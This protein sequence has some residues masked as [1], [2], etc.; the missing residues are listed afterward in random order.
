MLS[1]PLELDS[2]CKLVHIEMPSFVVNEQTLHT[3]ESF[4]YSTIPQSQ[5]NHIQTTTT[6][7][8][9]CQEIDEL[10]QRLFTFDLQ[11][12]LIKEPSS[13]RHM[14]LSLLS[15]TPEM[16]NLQTTTR[17]V[18]RR[19]LIGIDLQSPI[20]NFGSM[21][22]ED[23]STTC[24]NLVKQG[25]DTNVLLDGLSRLI[26]NVNLTWFYE[27][28][29]KLPLYVYEQLLPQDDKI[30]P[31]L[32]KYYPEETQTSITYI[33]SSV[34]NV[35][36]QFQM[37]NIVYVTDN[38]TI[39]LL[40]Q[41][42][43][44]DLEYYK[45]FITAY[46]QLLVTKMYHVDYPLAHVALKLMLSGL[47]LKSTMLD[48]VKHKLVWLDVLIDGLMG[49]KPIECLTSGFNFKLL[50]IHN[51]ETWQKLLN[52]DCTNALLDVFDNHVFAVLAPTFKLFLKPLTVLKDA[53]QIN[54]RVK[55]LRLLCFINQF[56]NP[57]L[58]SK[59]LSL[60]ASFSRDKS[61]I[62]RD[63]SL[64]SC[65]VSNMPS[66][67]L[68]SL[69]LPCLS[70]TSI[71]V[72]KT[73]IKFISSH[74]SPTHCAL[75][76]IQLLDKD[77][78]SV[79]IKA[80]NSLLLS[81]IPNKPWF[82]C[83]QSDQDLI[84]SQSK[85][86]SSALSYIRIH[87]KED[88]LS[89]LQ[90]FIESSK[91]KQ[92]DHFFQMTIDCIM[93]SQNNFYYCQLASQINPKWCSPY[94]NS[95][96]EHLHFDL[97]NTLQINTC[98]SCLNCLINCH[99]F[100]TNDHV[101]QFFQPLCLLLSNASAPILELAIKLIAL[102]N[103]NEV[104]HSQFQS[105]I[106]S[107]LVMDTNRHIIICALVMKYPSLHQFV[108]HSP[109]QMLQ[110]FKQTD[111]LLFKSC[112]DCC[113]GTPS[114]LIEMVELAVNNIHQM[115]IAE[116]VVKCILY[117]IMNDAPQTIDFNGNDAINTD[118]IEILQHYLP[119]LESIL[120][121]HPTS[122]SI[123][124]LIADVVNE[125]IKNGIIH[126]SQCCVLFFNL[127]NNNLSFTQHPVYQN[128]K[129]YNQ[130]A[131]QQLSK[132]VPNSEWL[133]LYKQ[134]L[135]KKLQK[136]LTFVLVHKLKT[137]ETHKW[138]EMMGDYELEEYGKQL[139]ERMGLEVQVLEELNIKNK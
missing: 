35:E 17:P 139:M 50:P 40:V 46:M 9:S 130:I 123:A 47:Y 110:S 65:I 92:L 30:L 54:V 79:V 27:L 81:H 20:I 134:D 56:L 26:G 73:A 69:I 55:T 119:I 107:C 58:Q 32:L 103:L 42:L 53:S 94:I 37:L 99:S 88:P 71:K 11:D 105:L 93:T 127:L 138:K 122:M 57:S 52:V 70:D 98:L 85:L 62:V 100:L 2:K 21:E 96:I 14:R 43:L 84:L 135:P 108:P 111:S 61:P 67:E 83:S 15:E 28:E 41:H 72:R 78:E 64:E 115:S 80:L 39:S 34:E 76:L 51:R 132:V 4:D 90:L 120:T 91:H 126:P 117:A 59:V 114:L 13:R 36:R 38:T 113:M 109:L 77:T 137:M 1:F 106:T 31:I 112:F 116:M 60:M 68:H 24:Q 129:K 49:I 87:K 124:T 44:N 104:H 63:A 89:Y 125:I 16:N 18:K 102:V 95:F 25:A 48:E 23:I 66:T 8:T 133:M 5:F 97:S 22:L 29:H 128:M 45:V 10:I 101:H 33:L 75:L 3:I 7:H 74:S 12:L 118:L 19:K 82:Q 121:I 136:Q 131:I 6:T 86:L